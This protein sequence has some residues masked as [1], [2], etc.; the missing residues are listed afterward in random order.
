MRVTFMYLCRH[1]NVICRHVNV[2]HG[3]VAS[4]KCLSCKCL[5]CKRGHVN[6]R[7][8]SASSCVPSWLPKPQLPSMQQTVANTIFIINI[9][10]IREFDSLY[11][12]LETVTTSPGSW[13]HSQ[14][15]SLL[16]VTEWV[17]QSVSESVSDK[18]CQWSDSGP[19][20]ISNHFVDSEFLIRIW[21]K[22][23]GYHVEM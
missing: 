21:P 6:E 18:H 5:S 7:H 12:L 10:N 23:V 11:Q 9:G 16:N 22:V 8:K 2:C 20:K 3:I 14:P 1:V 15:A 17:S 19:I 4:C 13:H